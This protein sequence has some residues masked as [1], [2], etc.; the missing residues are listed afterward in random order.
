M[1]LGIAIQKSKVKLDL[2]YG[3]LDVFFAPACSCYRFWINA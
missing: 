1:K 3:G 2:I